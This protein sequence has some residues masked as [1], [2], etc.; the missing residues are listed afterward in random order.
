MKLRPKLP[1][2]KDTEKLLA[3]TNDDFSMFNDAQ[4]GDLIT[5]FTP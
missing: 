1:D 2:L 3:I 5:Q 4:R